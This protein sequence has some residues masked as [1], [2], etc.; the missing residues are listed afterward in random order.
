MESFLVSG[1]LSGNIGHLRMFSQ[2]PSHQ[3]WLLSWLWCP[4]QLTILSLPRTHHS[5]LNEA[6]ISSAAVFQKLSGQFRSFLVNSLPQLFPLLSRQGWDSHFWN[7]APTASRRL[8][9]G[10]VSLQA[11]PPTTLAISSTASACSSFGFGLGLLRMGWRSPAVHPHEGHLFT[12]LFAWLAR[13]V[14]EF[15]C[16]SQSHDACPLEFPHLFPCGVSLVFKAFL[17]INPQSL[18]C[19]DSAWLPSVQRWSPLLLVNS[20]HQ[21]RGVPLGQLLECHRNRLFTETCHVVI[22]IMTLHDNMTFVREEFPNFVIL[23]TFHFAIHILHESMLNSYSI[24]ILLFVISIS[25]CFRGS[26]QTNYIWILFNYLST[27]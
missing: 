18:T 22:Q 16:G 3:P 21:L 25:S 27:I 19:L 9:E 20:E 10:L 2:H 6:L 14:S 15:M 23:R 4:L 7:L 12:C 24:C 11:L 5:C 26:I 8:P 1:D 17:I 13:E